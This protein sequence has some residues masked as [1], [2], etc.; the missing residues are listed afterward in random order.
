[1]VLIVGGILAN[2]ARWSIRR[3]G[4]RQ[5]AVTSTVQILARLVFFAIVAIAVYIALKTIGFD[6]GPLLAT[7]GIAGIVVGFALKD[8][9]ENYISGIIM[10]FRNP[11][12][13]GD[14]IHSGD[15]FGTVQELNLRYTK[16]ITPDG[17]LVFLPNSQ[18]L[19]NP[20]TNYTHDDN[21]RT[22]FTIGVAYG[23]DL[24]EA[25]QVAI[26]AV[27]TA[28]DVHEPG[29]APLSFESARHQPEA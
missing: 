4:K 29:P 11:F 15:V 20:L 8:L 23:T 27:S 2:A 9:A 19:T 25:R 24:D 26:D 18:V 13:P 17:L 3:F 10:G 22:D 28:K 16:I 7:A 6:L 21:I 14:Q 1:M 12:L 5:N